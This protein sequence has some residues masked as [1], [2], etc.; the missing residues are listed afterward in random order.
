M[1]CGLRFAGA[2]KHPHG[3]DAWRTNLA[4]MHFELLPNYFKFGFR[5]VDQE[6]RVEH[7]GSIRLR[8][9]LGLRVGLARS[10]SRR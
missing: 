1:V 4:L 7:V 2:V 6:V 10:R 9:A 8:R 5:S 3:S